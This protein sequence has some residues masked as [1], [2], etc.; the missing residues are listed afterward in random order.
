MSLN[1]DQNLLEM[2]SDD[3][4]VQSSMKTNW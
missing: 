4:V 2:F 1:E 3:L